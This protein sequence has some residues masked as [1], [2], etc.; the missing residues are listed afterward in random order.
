LKKANS[1]E[2]FLGRPLLPVEA[3]EN[4]L[5]AIPGYNFGYRQ[6]PG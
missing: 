5:T 6:L 4:G 2:N 1:G 3:N